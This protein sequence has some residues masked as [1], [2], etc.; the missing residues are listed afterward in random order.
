MQR[1]TNQREI[2]KPLALVDYLNG[3]RRGWW[4]EWVGWRIGG[5][6]GLGATWSSHEGETTVVLGEGRGDGVGHLWR[7]AATV[8]GASEVGAEE[9]NARCGGGA[10]DPAAQRD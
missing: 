8:V 4:A 2:S 5:S 7:A 9:L 1:Q 3:V 6:L 10:M